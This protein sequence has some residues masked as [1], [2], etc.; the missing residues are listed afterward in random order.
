MCVCVCV[1]VC[2]CVYRKEQYVVSLQADLRA[3][4]KQEFL[5]RLETEL[6]EMKGQLQAKAESLKVY[7]HAIIVEHSL[8]LV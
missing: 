8:L 7:V 3:A 4:P 5:E 6:K 2:A 1:S